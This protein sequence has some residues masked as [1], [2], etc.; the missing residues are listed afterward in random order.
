MCI[1]RAEPPLSAAHGTTTNTLPLTHN[2]SSTRLCPTTATRASRSMMRAFLFTVGSPPA[3]TGFL[4]LRF[5]ARG[6]GLSAAF[7][8][9]HTAILVIGKRLTRADEKGGEK[10]GGACVGKASRDTWPFQP[11]DTAVPRIRN[12]STSLH[13]LQYHR[14]GTHVV[15]ASVDYQTYMTHPKQ[16]APSTHTRCCGTAP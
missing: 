5:Q 3:I 7:P 4:H 9:L 11:A 12:Y 1:L 14:G 13:K 6:T 8:T 2:H 16:Q 10:K 15:L